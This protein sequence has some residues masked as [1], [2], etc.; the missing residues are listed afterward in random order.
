MKPLNCLTTAIAAAVLLTAQA[1]ASTINK[2]T[3]LPTVGVPYR[4]TVEM[5]GNDSGV[6]SNHVGAWS[7]EDNSLFGTGQPPVGWTHTADWVALTLTEGTYFTINVAQKA[8]V[9][10]P[11]ESDPDRTASI[12]SMFPSLTIW[13]GLDTDGDQVHTFNNHGNVSW[14]EDITFLDYYDNSS[15]ASIQRTWYLPAG[16]YTIVLGSNSP[17]SEDSIFRQ[18]YEA[19]F[20][21]ST[22]PEPSTVATLVGGLSAL[23]LVYARKRKK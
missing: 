2:A 7:W 9:P 15:A 4:F 17:A 11:S 23:A 3:S 5:A 19:T 10:W 21:T 16:T 18:G 22:V 20:T 1:Q 12:D 14:A 8:G 13:S 6:F